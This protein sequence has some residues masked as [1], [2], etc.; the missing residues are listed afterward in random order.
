[1]SS[2]TLSTN[3]QEAAARVKS[4]NP[5]DD[6][7]LELYGLYKIATEGPC[8]IPRPKSFLGARTKETAK[9][10]AWNGKNHLS[11]DDAKAKY[12]RLVNRI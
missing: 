2:D 10:D 5:D 3:F 12:V 9:W 6:T 11:P 8:T 1:M 7:K 4:L